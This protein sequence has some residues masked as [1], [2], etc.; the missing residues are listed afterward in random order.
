MKT[1]AAVAA[2]LW[3][4]S[5]A[6]ATNYTDPHGPGR[7]GAQGT[8]SDPDPSLR[9]VTFNVEYGREIERAAACLQAPPLRGAD[10]VL[11]QEMHARGAER[12]A[13]RLGMNFLYF[14]SS[15]RAGEREMGV[16]VLSPWPIVEGAKLILPHTTR[17]VHR[18][19]IATVATVRI[20]GVDVRVYSTHLGS[21]V[22]MGGGQ[23][24]EQAQAVLEHAREW[25]GP[26]IVG[27]DFNSRSV[28]SRFTAEGFSWP[29]A[30]LRHTV[31]LFAFDHVFVRGLPGTS[32]SGVA[33]ECS[34][35]DHSPVWADLRR[36]REPAVPG[37][38]R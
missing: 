19:R 4:T 29:T 9:V 1:R 26:V 38:T 16:A 8:V 10:L 3:L 7:S 27:G 36:W 25:K 37:G 6:V 5:C 24:G 28:A 18:L 35:S 2:A 11:L 31:G 15:V 22:G 13:A 21:P 34:A 30:S 33:R 20:D 12:I 23:R 14:P 32:E 17:V